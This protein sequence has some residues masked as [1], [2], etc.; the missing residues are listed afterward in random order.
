MAL[1][2]KLGGERGRLRRSHLKCRRGVYSGR[3]IKRENVRKKKTAI[4]RELEEVDKME[5]E[6]E[7]EQEGRKGKKRIEREEEERVKDQECEKAKRLK[8]LHF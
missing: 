3:A 6:E 5:E 7:E 8:G 1:V 2:E 4:G